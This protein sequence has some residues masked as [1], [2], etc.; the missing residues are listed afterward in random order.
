MNTRYLQTRISSIARHGVS[1][2]CFRILILLEIL[3]E[4]HVTGAVKLIY[5]SL[6]N[7]TLFLLPLEVIIVNL[8]FIAPV[9]WSYTACLCPENSICECFKT[10][11]ISHKFCA[12]I[13]VFKSHISLY[14]IC[15]YNTESYVLITIAV[16]CSY[17]NCVYSSWNSYISIDTERTLDKI[18]PEPEGN[19]LNLVRVI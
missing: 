6:S 1:L 3:L 18:Q 7:F 10:V 19:C 12:Y 4:I 5:V 13:S 15:I 2:H 16:V 14:V 8:L 11:Y 17:F 9:H